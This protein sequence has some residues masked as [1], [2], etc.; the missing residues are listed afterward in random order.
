MSAIPK[1]DDMR[2]YLNKTFTIS[3]EGQG[4]PDP[5]EME[6]REVTDLPTPPEGI[7]ANSEPYTM[8]F[9]AP[10]EA[11]LPQA[12]YTVSHKE[13]GGQHMFMVPLGPTKAGDATEFQVIF[14]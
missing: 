8:I 2:K 10:K 6:L 7:K 4:A 5:V 3:T 1:R 13:I 11:N 9:R 12:I 14:N